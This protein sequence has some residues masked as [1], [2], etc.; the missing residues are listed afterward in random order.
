M[1]EAEWLVS[2]E[3]TFM[4]SAI[5]KR[6]STRKLYLLS[7]ACIFQ[8]CRLSKKGQAAF[9]AFEAAAD[10][11]NPRRAM[12]RATTEHGNQWGYDDT[13]WEEAERA[14]RGPNER[15]ARKVSPL[16]IR[17][18]FGNPFRPVAFDPSWRS[19]TVVALAS[20]MYESRDFGAMPIL[21]DA[22]QDTGCENEDILG[23]CRGPGPHVRGCWLVDTLLTK[24]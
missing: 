3:P 7:V 17:D 2:S 1:T 8:L 22:L 6:A 4:L 14:A 16:L 18:V 15:R 19:S 21:A 24:E 23:H 5:R 11:P 13:P 9:A 20:Q 12:K 10:A